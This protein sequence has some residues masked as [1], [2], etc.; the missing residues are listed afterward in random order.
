VSARIFDPEN[1]FQVFAE[2]RFCETRSVLLSGP[3]GEHGLAT[4]FAEFLLGHVCIPGV[5]MFVQQA[6][7]QFEI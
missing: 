3:P 7:R 1:C 4:L 5:E 6:A 2:S